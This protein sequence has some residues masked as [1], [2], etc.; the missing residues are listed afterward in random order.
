MKGV[1]FALKKAPALL[2]GSLLLALSA[3]AGCKGAT[4]K[5]NEARGAART[6]W[7]DYV[8]ALEH[9]QQQAMRT[10]SESHAKLSTEIEHR[11][12]PAAQKLA[13]TR[14]DRNNSAWL[15]AYQSA[16]HDACDHDA[17]CKSTTE[18]SAQA[19]ATLYD[20]QDRIPLARAA[21]AASDGP[22]EAAKGASAAVIVHPEYP[23]LK[24][25]Q[26]LSD[27]AYA[28]CKDLAPPK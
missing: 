1:R 19:K 14:Y 20:L 5:C 6:A 16:Y 27:A 12:A 9:T 26:Q 13:D 28:R 25:A 11:L 4:E 10:Q 23:Q 17:E 15:R 18:R 8:S 21:L 2:H 7:E 24:Q 3:T 22:A